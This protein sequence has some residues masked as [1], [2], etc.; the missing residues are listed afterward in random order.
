M[1]AKAIVAIREQYKNVS[2]QNVMYLKHKLF[3]KYIS[4]KTKSLL[5]SMCTLQLMMLLPSICEPNHIIGRLTVLKITICIHVSGT[6]MDALLK[7]SQ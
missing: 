6:V 1:R 4:I 3:D 7:P 5:P 2:N